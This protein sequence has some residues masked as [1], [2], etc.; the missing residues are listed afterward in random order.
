MRHEVSV[1]GLISQKNVLQIRWRMK[2]ITKN[3]YYIVLPWVKSYFCEFSKW[4]PTTIC[5]GLARLGSTA[6]FI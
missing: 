4:W 3:T 2:Y 1:P 6:G 5:S